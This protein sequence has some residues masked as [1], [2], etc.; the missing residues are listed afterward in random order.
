MKLSELLTEAK[1]L[2]GGNIPI[3]QLRK[4]KELSK[5]KLSK[6]FIGDGAQTS[7][8][9]HPKTPNSVIKIGKVENVHKD[10]PLQFISIA[11][12][13]Q[14]NPFFPRIYKAKLYV[15]H[16]YGGTL[17]VEMERL[18]PVKD[19]NLQHNM[20]G[21]FKNILGVDEKALINI[22]KQHPAYAGRK[23]SEDVPIEALITRSML[24][25]SQLKELARISKNEQFTEA[26]NSIAGVKGASAMLDLH[27]G[28]MMFR[29]TSVGPQL[30]IV[31]P[32]YYDTIDD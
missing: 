12:K 6:H 9:S 1:K 26:I 25:S 16:E 23:V 5:A 3:I 29:L 31:D 7:V 8:Y 28:N 14:D 10:G 24:S 27:P 21:I 13:H 2:F 4:D 17:Y 18:H 20:V 32:F 22:V 19:A 11:L 30:V 15:H